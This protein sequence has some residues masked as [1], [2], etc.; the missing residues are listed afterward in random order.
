MVLTLNDDF[1]V[2]LNKIRG[3]NA[4]FDILYFNNDAKIVII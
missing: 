2:I 1:F 4:N 3:S